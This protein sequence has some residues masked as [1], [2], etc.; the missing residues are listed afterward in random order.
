MWIRI[1]R[2]H[3]IFYV[4]EPLVR[5]RRHDT[6][7]SRHADRMLE[8]MRKV[9]RKALRAGVIPPGR[10]GARLK[11][12]AVE[13]FQAGWMYWDER[14]TGRALFHAALS[15]LVWPCPLDY[16]DLHEPPFFRLRAAIRFLLGRRAASIS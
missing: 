9:R 11:L 2:Q 8:S 4:D 15:L 13:H 12:L 6:N 3:R 7:M 5:I 1:G 10:I 16:F 14:R